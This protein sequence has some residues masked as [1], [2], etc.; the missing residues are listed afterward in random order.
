M[1]VLAICVVNLLA[2]LAFAWDKFQ[3]TRDGR[4]VPRV[5]LLSLLW[6][7]PFLPTGCMVLLRH[8]IRKRLFMV[9]SV[10]AGSF[11][12]M[13]IFWFL[14]YHLDWPALLAGAALFVIW[15]L[16]LGLQWHRGCAC[17]ASTLH[18]RDVATTRA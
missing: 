15:A 7:A 16:A 8:K 3:A 11:Q 9:S 1:L 10:L 18:A 13:G 6:I 14:R 5:H 2:S 17:E 12:S 4:R